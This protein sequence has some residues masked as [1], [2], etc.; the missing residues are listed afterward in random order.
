MMLQRKGTVF[1]AIIFGFIA[2]Q[3]VICIVVA[4]VFK[5]PIRVF[6]QR[7]DGQSNMSWLDDLSG[8]FGRRRERIELQHQILTQHQEG[9]IPGDDQEGGAY[10]L[11]AFSENTP[12]DEW[13]LEIAS[14]LEAGISTHLVSG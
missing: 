9:S 11:Q 8:W 10:E 7:D 1:P 13:A 12:S 14:M 5:G 4:L 6:L 3:I 2:L